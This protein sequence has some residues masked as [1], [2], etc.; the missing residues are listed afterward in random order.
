[1]ER[2]VFSLVKVTVL[3]EECSQL[4]HSRAPLC[5]PEAKYS[6]VQTVR[7]GN[8]QSLC[9][10]CNPKLQTSRPQSIHPL[11]LHPKCSNSDPLSVFMF[12]FCLWAAARSHF[13]HSQAE[14]GTPHQCVHTR[15]LS[16]FT[17]LPACTFAVAVSCTP[18]NIFAISERQQRA[19]SRWQSTKEKVF[20][21]KRRDTKSEL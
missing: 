8:E 18:V 1:M 21:C 5:L 10:V 19:K 9:E 17:R 2:L 4:P 7:G 13:N 12:Q 6:F 11:S 3:S 16:V 15:A 14:E 20:F